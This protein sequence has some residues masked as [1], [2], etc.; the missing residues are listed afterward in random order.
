VLVWPVAH[1]AASAGA[2]AGASPNHPAHTGTNRP[3]S[4]QDGMTGAIPSGTLA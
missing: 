3:I 4:Y 2:G 1:P